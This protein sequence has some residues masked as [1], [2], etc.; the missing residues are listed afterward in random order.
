MVNDSDGG[1][2]IALTLIVARLC[3]FRRLSA[4]QERDPPASRTI[5][6]IYVVRGIQV[7]MPRGSIIM[8]PPMGSHWVPPG[9]GSL[10]FHCNSISR[11]STL[12]NSPDNIAPLERTTSNF[13]PMFLKYCLGNFKAF[14]T[15][16]DATSRLS[17]LPLLPLTEARI[18]SSCSSSVY[19]L[20]QKNE[21]DV[22]P[23]HTIQHVLF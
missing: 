10:C 6:V 12:V 9:F 18:V 22:I 21:A 15:P 2:Q 19:G 8:D 23:K 3:F 1:I 5:G 13:L 16:A 11:S 7:W 14:P 4:R 20:I 17:I